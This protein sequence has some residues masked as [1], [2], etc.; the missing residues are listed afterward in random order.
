[1]GYGLGLAALTFLIIGVGDIIIAS[2][3]HKSSTTGIIALLIGLGIL[4]YMY[5]K[6]N[7]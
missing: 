4:A 5:F 7:K 3:S 6:K 1:M 2:F